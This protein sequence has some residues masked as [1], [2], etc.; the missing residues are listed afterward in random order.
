[1]R[2]LMYITI[3][4]AA[5]CGACAYMDGALAKYGAA[6]ALVVLLCL[7]DRTC[8]FRRKLVLS[9]LGCVL[10]FVWFFQF[11]GRY[12]APVLPMDGQTV[13]MTIRASDYGAITDHATFFDGS[14]TFSDQTYSVRTRLKEETEVEPGM[15]VSGE[16][17]IRAALTG[18]RPGQ[19]IFL[20]A[21]Q[22][23]ELTVSRSG[24]QWTDRIAALRRELQLTLNRVFPEDVRAF[25]KALFLGDTSDLPYDVDTDLKVSGVRHIVAVSGL[26]ISILFGLLSTVTF[27]KRF[28]MVLV[29]YPTLFF[30]AALTGFTPSVVRACLMAGLMLLAKLADREYDGPTSLSFAVLVMLVLNPLV[31]TA[32]GFQMSVGSVAGIFLFTPGLVGWM[33]SFF[34]TGRGKSLRGRLVRWGT[35]SI[36]VTLGA[37]ALVTPLCAYYF[38]MVSLVGVLANLLTLWMISL[39]FYGIM[40]VCLLYWAIPAAAFVLAKGIAWPIR[41]VLWTAELLADFPLAAVYTRSVYMSAWLVFLYALLAVFLIGRNRKPGMLICCAVIGLCLAF[42]ADWMESLSDDVRLTV[43]DVGQGQSILLQSEGRSFLVDCGG[44]YGDEAAD[45]AAEALLCQGIGRLDGMILTHLDADHSNGAAGLL[46]RVETELLVLPEAYSQL[47]GCTDAQILCVTETL[48]IALKDTVITIYPPTFPGNEN[49]KSLCVLF[50][51][52]KCDILIIGDRDGYGERSLL[53][54]AKI[55]DVDILIAGHHGSASSTCVQ[56]LEA[57]KPEIVCISAGAGNIYGHPAP[58]LLQR[59]AEFGCEIYRTDIQ[60]TITIRR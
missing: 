16:F 35:A 52:Q 33:R 12:L 36:G 9:V 51:T 29:G 57:V 56:L 60:G 1:M 31:I 59:L 18:I 3:G 10:G 7:P 21:Y 4:F 24:G 53:R 46:S 27:R 26:H 14:V 41:F 37:S 11:Q 40:A 13:P 49:E 44:D 17:Y 55:P 48:E 23:G 34:E 47:P 58:E 6:A 5:A 50:D 38:G 25:A 20:A 45:R 22:K 43:L 30:F 32:A 15:L 54:N 39:I 42:A 8:F 2:R 28:L 19:G